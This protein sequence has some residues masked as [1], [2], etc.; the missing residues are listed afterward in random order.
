MARPALTIALLLR[1]RALVD[2]C[3]QWLPVN[4]YAPVD[5]GEVESGQ[6]VLELL[7]HQREA[8]DAVVIEQSLLDGTTRE[9]LG[10][11]GLLFP[12]VVVG[13]LMGRVDYHPEEVHLPGDQLEQL[14][15]N[16]D[17]A[18]SRFLRQ[19]QK[20]VMPEDGAE[21][22]ARPSIDGSAWR[23]SS[24]LQE[25]LGYLGVFYKRDP[26]RFLAN[27]PL[28]EQRDLVQSLQRTY[29]D[30]LISYFRDPAAANQA[31]ESFVNTAFF[32][33]LPITRAVEI[34][35]NL[36]DEFWKQLRLEGHKNDFL[37]DY[38]LALLDVMAHLCEM[39]RRSIP[40]EV[41]LM[42]SAGERR[43]LNEPEVSP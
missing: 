6:Q 17:A 13:D 38:R 22:N 3:C 18:I 43:I 28:D 40:A 4:R 33:D 16:V 39:Y 11:E 23:M 7:S 20:E 2:V 31:L 8:V 30:L 36:I 15:Y 35:M 10:Q 9:S 1:T 21:Q 14:G 27:L 34:H 26:S 25:R 37:Q 19:G 41:P 12:A 32:G 5:L 24:R 29:R 42:P